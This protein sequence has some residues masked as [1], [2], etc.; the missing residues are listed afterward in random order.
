MFK[1]LFNY[2][3]I[4]TTLATQDRLNTSDTNF[5]S[6][7]PTFAHVNAY[8]TT[9]LEIHFIHVGNKD[10]YYIFKTCCILCFIYHKMLFIS[11]FH[12]FLFKYYTHFSLTM[13]Q[14]LNNSVV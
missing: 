14:N 8:K 12:L 13:C 2:L 7:Q 10:I 5:A 6:K 4:P 3:I 1:L 9:P 11:Q